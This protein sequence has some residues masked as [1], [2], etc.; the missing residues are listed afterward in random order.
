LRAIDEEQAPADEAAIK[1]L[2]W[3]RSSS[4]SKMNEVLPSEELIFRVDDESSQHKLAQ[5]AS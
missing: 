4:G 2:C 5:G 3:L 1:G